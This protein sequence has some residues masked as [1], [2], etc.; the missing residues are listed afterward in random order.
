MADGWTATSVVGN[1][2][3]GGG[4]TVILRLAISGDILAKGVVLSLVM[5]VLGGIL[6][7]LSAMRMR[8]LEA[9]R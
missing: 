3:Q 8:P 5:G 1:P 7:S 4:K 6:P 9:L 2:Q